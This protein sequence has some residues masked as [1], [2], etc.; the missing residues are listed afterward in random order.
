MNT[1][2]WWTVFSSEHF[3]L[4]FYIPIFS[5]EGFSHPRQEPVQSILPPGPSPY[6][7]CSEVT[8]SSWGLPLPAWKYPQPLSWLLRTSQETLFDS[9]SAWSTC[10]VILWEVHTP[11]CSVPDA[12]NKV[13]FSF[14]NIGNRCSLS[15]GPCSFSEKKRICVCT[16]TCKWNR[17]PL[18]FLCV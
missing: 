13:A 2:C 12:I 8:P 15:V 16:E 14:A 7:G 18:K 1:L 17:L 10:D 3:P 4:S 6:P 5:G 9:F 11:A